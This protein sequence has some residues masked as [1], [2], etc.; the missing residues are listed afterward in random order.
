[1][2]KISLLVLSVLF[3]NSATFAQTSNRYGG[4]GFLSFG[5]TELRQSGLNSQL[6]TAGYTGLASSQLS[7]G[8]EGFGILNN[9]VIGGRGGGLGK[10]QFSN[11]STTGNISNSYGS[12]LLGYTFSLGKKMLFYPLVGFGG[13]DS[14]ITIENPTTTNSMTTA[15]TNPNQITVINAEVPVLDFSVNFVVPVFGNVAGGGGPM[16][17]I[18]AGYIFSPTAGNYRMNGRELTNIPSGQ[19]NGFYVRMLF[20]GGGFGG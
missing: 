5:L 11:G 3:W 2:K 15:F 20:G 18:S 9:F 7:F 12:F 19:I 13:I 6:I 1:M 14:E 16:L 10:Q 4:M 8:G 17:G